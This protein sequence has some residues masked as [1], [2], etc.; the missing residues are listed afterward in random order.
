[1]TA[2]SKPAWAFSPVKR[3]INS[4]RKAFDSVGDF[5]GMVVSFRWIVTRKLDELEGP[6]GAWLELRLNPGAPPL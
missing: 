1:L 2:A 4:L 6:V 3:E 5:S